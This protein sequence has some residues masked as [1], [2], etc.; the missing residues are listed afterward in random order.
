[1]T[2]SMEK[3]QTGIANRVTFLQCLLAALEPWMAI[4][5]TV[6]GANTQLQC[7]ECL[8]MYQSCYFQ[9]Q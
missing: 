6:V 1:M 5:E 9:Q 3:A 4:A 8:S 2:K 7:F